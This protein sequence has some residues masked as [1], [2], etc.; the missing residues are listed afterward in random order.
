MRKLIF[1]IFTFTSL[2]S[3]AT[4]GRATDGLSLNEA[5]EQVAGELSSP[6]T[7]KTR[8]A[9]VSFESESTELSEYII[10]ELTA[11]L[12]DKGLMDIA[13]RRNLDYIRKELDLQ[14]S[15]EVDDESAVSIGKF[16][17]AQKI[18]VG[19]LLNTGNGYRFRVVVLNVESA[20]R[21]GGARL[22]VRDDKILRQLITALGK[23]QKSPSTIYRQS[24]TIVPNTAGAYLDRGIQFAVRGDFDIAIED[25]TEALTLD[26][27]F[28]A[29]YLQ[30]GKS[31]LASI[32][33]V[34]FVSENF[35]DFDLYVGTFVQD[36]LA[37]ANS[38]IDD[39]TKAITLNPTAN[40]YKYRGICY[41]GLGDLDKA[42]ADFTQ[43]IRLAPNNVSI[44]NYRSI[45]YSKKKDYDRAIADCN[46][47]IKIDQN[48]F[49]GYAN[50]GSYYSTIDDYDRS[51]ENCKKAIKLEPNNGFVPT[52]QFILEMAY[53][54]RGRSSFSKKDYNRAIADFT[55]AINL[56]NDFAYAYYLRG[57][58]YTWKDDFNKAIQD[59]ERALRINPDYKEAKDALLE[60]RGW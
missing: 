15:G 35:E 16:V 41:A 9:I 12:Y 51:I 33:D 25:F 4:T 42:L 26:Q 36:V 6:T 32:S 54:S 40:A 57:N 8:L 34:V 59:W 3:C 10:E 7:A 43:G 56:D 39:L 2:V 45:A 17:G 22:N 49:L 52:V 50:L 29:A 44:Y 1:G 21:E 11:A 28:A 37:T 14:Y 60:I 20:T 55:E 27:N 30:R 19:E 47:A 31:L 48:Y 24:E 23:R 13:D 53:I 46:K 18:V 5:I 38:S 58:A